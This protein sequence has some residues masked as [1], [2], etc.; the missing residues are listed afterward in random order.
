MFLMEAILTFAYCYPISF[1]SHPEVFLPGQDV[2]V[3]KLRLNIM[4]SKL[5]ITN[6]VV[7]KFKYDFCSEKYLLTTFSVTSCY[8][9]AFVHNRN[10]FKTS[11]K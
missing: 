9:F 5:I 11:R 6:E 3:S 10:R 7:N 8:G 2:S 4:A 1:K